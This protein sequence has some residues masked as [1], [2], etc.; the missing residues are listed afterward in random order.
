M[1]TY[2]SGVCSEVPCLPRPFWYS[3][4]SGKTEFEKRRFFAQDPAYTKQNI[5]QGTFRAESNYYKAMHFCAAAAKPWA[6]KSKTWAVSIQ[7]SLTYVGRRDNLS[8]WAFSIPINIFNLA[9]PNPIT[10]L[11]LHWI[12]YEK[13]WS[14]RTHP[15]GVSPLSRETLGYLWAA[16]GCKPQPRGTLALPRSIPPYYNPRGGVL[17]STTDEDT[18]NKA[19]GR[20]LLQ[21]REGKCH[22]TVLPIE[23]LWL[24]TWPY[25]PRNKLLAVVNLLNRTGS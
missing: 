1:T 21:L 17:T 12:R 7:Y 6:F 16:P 23:N 20:D 22:L 3:Y 10:F 25:R 13:N 9:M 14:S 24:K 11:S 5:K 18:K 15:Q 4:H 19:H 2:R 8:G